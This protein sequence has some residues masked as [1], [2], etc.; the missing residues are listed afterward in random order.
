MASNFDAFKAG[1][2]AFVEEFSKTDDGAKPLPPARKALLITCMDGE[3]LGGG[4]WGIAILA[5]TPPSETNHAPSP[6]AL[7]LHTARLHPEK[8]LGVD[9]GAW[10]CL[11]GWELVAC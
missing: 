7:H 11:G 1:N 3:W 10:H 6:C 4:W 9:I 8:A 5:C 2:A